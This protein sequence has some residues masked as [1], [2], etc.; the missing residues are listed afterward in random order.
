MYLHSLEPG[1]KMHKIKIEEFNK[2]K[3]HH[4]HHKH[5]HKKHSKHIKKHQKQHDNL[6]SKKNHIHHENNKKENVKDKEDPYSHKPLYIFL[7]CGGIN[8]LYILLRIF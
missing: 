5:N 6:N 4:K 7:T 2:T 8:V 3:K 1:L